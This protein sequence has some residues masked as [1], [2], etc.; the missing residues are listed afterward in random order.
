MQTLLTHGAPASEELGLRDLPGAEIFL[1]GATWDADGDVSIPALHIR[2]C[3]A[4]FAKVL[5]R[6]EIEMLVELAELSKS[7]RRAEWYSR[8]ILGL[9][10]SLALVGLVTLIW[11]SL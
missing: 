8:L 3:P 1:V 4:G 11:Q 5:A 6:A 7:N 2:N 10:L 9:V